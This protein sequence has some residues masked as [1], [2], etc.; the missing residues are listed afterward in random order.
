[1]AWAEQSGAGSWRVRYPKADGTL[2]SVPGFP[3]KKAAQHHAADL[4]ARQRAGTF[5]D[6][7]AGQT[8]FADWAQQW[9]AALDVDVRTYEG[10]ESKLRT[11]LLPRWGTASLS[12]I[13]ATQVGVWT[14]TLRQAGLAD[15]TVTDITKLLSLMLAD[16]VDERLIAA[17]PVRRR[18]RGRRRATA[19]RERIWAT[20]EQVVRIADNAAATYGHAG[21]ILITTA[22]FTGARWGELC[23]LQRHHLNLTTGQLH[24]D[25]THGALHE[26]AAGRLWLGPPKTPE[27]ARSIALPAFLIPLLADY[28]TSHQHRHVFVTPEQALHRRSNFSRRCMRRSAD[29]HPHTHNVAPLDAVCPGLV[30]H[31][32]RHSHKTWMIADGIPDVAQARRLGH[33]L[34]DRI[35]DIYSHV[36][37]EIETRLLHGLETRWQDALATI[38]TDQPTPP[39]RATSHHP[40]A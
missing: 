8:R 18:R 17:N 20:P 22:A 25:T 10:Y 21:A 33:K 3:T 37:A 9:L 28:L 12:S 23:G 14:K 19:R 35:D 13:T 2:G 38:N 31:G 5:L 6:P 30:F 32:L 16:A 15:V 26:S 11:H 36:A 39:W 4:D 29:G 27:S 7:A 24:I 40:A 34:P 1:M